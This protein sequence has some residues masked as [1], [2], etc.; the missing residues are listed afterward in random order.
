MGVHHGLCHVLGGR[1]KPPHGVLNAIVLPHGC[2]SH[3]DCGEGVPMTW[4][5]R[6]ASSRI[7]GMSKNGVCAAVSEFVRGLGVPQ[8]LRDPRDP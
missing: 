3:P 4:Q 5:A 6:C 8:R 2:D 1:Y 7:P